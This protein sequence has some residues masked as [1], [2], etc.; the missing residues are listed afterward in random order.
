MNLGGM[1]GALWGTNVGA[2]SL[3]AGMTGWRWA[4]L[5][6]AMASGVSGVLT[7]VCATEPR[8]TLGGGVLLMRGGGAGTLGVSQTGLGMSQTGSWS[9]SDVGGGGAGEER[10]MLAWSTHGGTDGVHGQGGQQHGQHGKGDDA[11]G[12]IKRIVLLPTFGIIILQVCLLLYVCVCVL[13]AVL[14]CIAL[15]CM[16]LCAH[17]YSSGM[18]T[19]TSHTLSHTHQTHTTHTTPCHT[20]SHHIMTLAS[21]HTITSHHHISPSHRVLQEHSLG[22]PCHGQPHTCSS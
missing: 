6:V 19:H 22:S 2:R 13:C 17:S 10:D 18:E 11:W 14:L 7:Y 4:F 12:A 1:L 9:G 8:S 16:L 20:P 15:L 3:V 5:G 21:H